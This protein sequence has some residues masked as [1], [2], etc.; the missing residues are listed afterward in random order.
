MPDCKRVLIVVRTYPSPALKGIEVS[1]TAGITEKGEWIR[2]F[3]VPYRFIDYDK[4]FSKYNLIDVNVTSTSDGRIESHHLDIDSI[5]IV[6]H[7]DTK[8]NWS[9]RKKWVMPLVAHC[10]CCLKKERDA[11]K[12]PTLGVF[13]PRTIRRLI[14]KP[15]SPDWTE[16]E[17]GKLRQ[18]PLFNVAPTTELEKIP[19]QFAYEFQCDHDECN[20]HTLSCPDWEMAESYRAWR[21]YYGDDEWEKRFRQRYE[22]EMI[23]KKDTH[24]YVGTM[25]Q[26]QHLWIIIGLFYPM[27]E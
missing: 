4:R 21:K 10:L 22:K 9:E 18:M 16:K 14:L 5:S 3:P 7:L 27:R 12:S 13:K 6:D 24:F 1:C 20:G 17:L 23:E 25:A 11:N 15:E 2:L 26:H 19:F 8:K